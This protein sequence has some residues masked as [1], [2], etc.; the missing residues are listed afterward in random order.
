METKK[1]EKYFWEFRKELVR[2]IVYG[3]RQ[4]TRIAQLWFLTWKNWFKVGKV[5]CTHICLRCGHFKHRPTVRCDCQFVFFLLDAASEI[6]ELVQTVHYKSMK[7]DALFLQGSIIT[8]FRWGVHYFICVKI[9]SCLQQSKNY[10][11]RLRFV[12]LMLKM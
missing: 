7:Y 8:I 2:L 9:S 12:K 11:N 4:T 6:S 1:N 5:S 3:K 10:A